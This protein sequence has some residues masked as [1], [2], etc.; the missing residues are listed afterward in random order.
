MSRCPAYRTR[1]IAF[2]AAAML[3]IALPGFGCRAQELPPVAPIDSTTKIQVVMGD[4]ASVFDLRQREDPAKP[5]RMEELGLSVFGDRYAF[6]VAKKE[7]RDEY[8]FAFTGAKG[9]LVVIAKKSGAVEVGVV[10]GNSLDPDSISPCL[11]ISTTRRRVKKIALRYAGETVRVDLVPNFTVGLGKRSVWIS[12]PDGNSYMT[13]K[14][15]ELPGLMEAF[16]CPVL[17]TLAFLL[18][19]KLVCCAVLAFEKNGKSK[20]YHLT[21]VPSGSKVSISTEVRDDTKWDLKEMEG[22]APVVE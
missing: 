21:A 9:L 6:T 18:D 13:R 2:L 7:E 3:F 12:F 5:S 11:Q 15:P 10:K 4:S 16:G 17:R 20:Y 14:L 19:G 1:A 22:T 8:A